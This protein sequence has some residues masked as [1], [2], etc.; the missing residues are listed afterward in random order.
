MADR[1]P[2]STLK[3]TVYSFFSRNP[4]SNL[5][6]VDIA[7]FARGDAVLDIGCGPGAA[8]RAAA[9]HVARAV[10]VDRASGMVA[11][12]DQRSAGHGNVEF[13]AGS[14]ENLPFDAGEFE[15]VWTIRAFHH[16]EDRAA[17]MA[18]AH[19]VLKPGG[20]FL[21]VENETKGKHGLTLA[22]AEALDEQLKAAGFNSTAVAKHAS[23]IVVTA[24]A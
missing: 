22:A 10:G 19:R 20:R 3:S 18:E 5:A 4:K 6:I 24:V 13:A 1:A 12:A 17:G 16:W 23:N 9:P 11:I 14:A 15:W 8:V 2:W 7:D 21:I